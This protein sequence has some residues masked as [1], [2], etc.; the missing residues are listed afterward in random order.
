MRN[1]TQLER[2]L[3]LC[4]IQA[5]ERFVAAEAAWIEHKMSCRICSGQQDGKVH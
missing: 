5:S 2:N 3:T 1:I 4:P